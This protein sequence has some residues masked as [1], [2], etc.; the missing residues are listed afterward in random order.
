LNARAK[1]AYRITWPLRLQAMKKISI[2]SREKRSHCKRH[3]SEN[4]VTNQT[5]LYRG[6]AGRSFEAPFFQLAD[7]VNVVGAKMKKRLVSHRSMSVTSK[8]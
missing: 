3:K 7:Y 1:N 4:D 5:V 6:I 2:E 8:P